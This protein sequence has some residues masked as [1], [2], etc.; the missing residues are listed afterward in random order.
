MD[1][2][3]AYA[4][5]CSTVGLAAREGNVKVLRKLLKKGR[6]ID[7]ADNRGWMPI[8]EAAYHNSVECLRLLIH[9]GKVNS[10]YGRLDLQAGL[11]KK[12]VIHD[13]LT[14]ICLPFC[15][16]TV[17]ASVLLRMVRLPTLNYVSMVFELD[18]YKC[19]TLYGGACAWL[20]FIAKLGDV[21][22]VVCCFNLSIW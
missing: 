13:L 14:V 8:H 1:F 17:T 12:V 16:H 2:T 19:C 7:V 22:K 18:V 11:I 15:N 4:D 10:R 6:S 9:A 5:T 21:A 20:V 3:E